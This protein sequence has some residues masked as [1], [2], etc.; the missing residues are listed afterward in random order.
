[1]LL[2]LLYTG[3]L[4]RLGIRAGKESTRQGYT[5]WSTKIQ[6]LEGNMRMQRQSM[7]EVLAPTASIW[8]RNRNFKLMYS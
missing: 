7:A 3:P 1:M 5:E 6:R 4:C 2:V 8:Q